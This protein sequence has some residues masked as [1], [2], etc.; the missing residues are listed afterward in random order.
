MVESSPLSQATDRVD[1]KVKSNSKE[2]DASKE[3]KSFTFEVNPLV[4]LSEGET[5]KG[6]QSFPSVEA[7]K[8]TTVIFL[9][10]GMQ[11]FC[12]LIFGSVWF[13][14]WII[15]RILNY[16]SSEIP[17]FCWSFGKECRIFF[18]VKLYFIIVYLIL[19]KVLLFSIVYLQVIL[20]SR[21]GSSSPNQTPQGI[22]NSRKRAFLESK[23][24]LLS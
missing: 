20:N 15:P 10:V 8:M 4:V 16:C 22:S 5:G 13:V 17:T 11:F 24:H 3:E 9:Y 2:S 6:W 21:R 12:N 14:H 23:M 1:G 7:C 18:I 19:I